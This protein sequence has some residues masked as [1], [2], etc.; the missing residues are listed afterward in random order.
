MSV[1]MAGD[2]C[3]NWRL[4]WSNALGRGT[5]GRGLIIHQGLGSRKINAAFDKVMEEIAMD[6][7]VAVSHGAT[8][9]FLSLRKLGISA[10]WLC[11]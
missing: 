6:R 8:A 10:W 4:R 9:L 3:K 2:I 7:V 1:S 11:A 5:S